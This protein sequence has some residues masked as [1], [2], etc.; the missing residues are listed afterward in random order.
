[1]KSH[2][3]VCGIRPIIE[4]IESGQHISKLLL[5]YQL[6]GNKY[7]K[8]YELIILYGIPVQI[9]PRQRLNRVAGNTHQGVLAFISP[10]I[11]YKIDKILPYLYEIYGNPLLLIIDRVNDVRNLG[12]IVR[13][14][15]CTGVGAIIIPI[16]KTVTINYHMIKASAGSIFKIP[17]CKQKNINNILFLLKKYGF[18]IISTNEKACKIF[19]NCNYT[20]PISIILG[21]EQNGISKVYLN[22]SDE[23]VKLPMLGKISS[24][25]V[26]VTCG[27]MLYEVLRKR[28]KY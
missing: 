6:S 7:K 15:E 14:A 2:N 16:K 23:H 13:T 25:N 24:L 21:N 1:M 12:A 5:Q 20:R 10:I 17:I 4:A 28:L 19:T 11:Y 9:V 3:I 22:I 8:L 26:S 27:V 18:R